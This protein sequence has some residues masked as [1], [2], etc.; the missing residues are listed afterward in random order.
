MGTDVGIMDLA[1]GFGAAAPVIGLLLWWILRQDKN[2]E[3]WRTEA[4]AERDALRADLKAVQ[5]DN[6]EMLKET[7]SLGVS[8]KSLLERIVTKVGA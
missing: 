4:K 6:I 2:F 8:L 3:T 5:E 7:V 1:K